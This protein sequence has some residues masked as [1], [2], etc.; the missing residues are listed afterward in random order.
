MHVSL[1]YKA[2]STIGLIL[3]F[4]KFFALS[5]KINLGFTTNSLNIVTSLAV[6]LLKTRELRFLL[7][8][9]EVPSRLPRKPPPPTIEARLEIM[10]ENLIGIPPGSPLGLKNSLGLIIGSLSGSLKLSFL[11]TCFAFTGIRYPIKSSGF[12]DNFLIGIFL[13]V[14]DGYF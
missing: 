4:I 10:L 3:L 13:C 8:F 9:R 12:S 11:G 1:C 14:S 5:Y 6:K 7:Y 2:S